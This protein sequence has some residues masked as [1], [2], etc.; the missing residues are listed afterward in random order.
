MAVLV[1]QTPA[2]SQV[3]AGVNA[4]PTQVDATH[5]V[6][7]AYRRQAAEPSQK[8]SVPHELAPWSVHWLSGSWPA[9]TAVHVPTLPVSAHDWQVPVQAVAQ[10]KPCAQKPELHSAAAPQAAPIGFL[11]Q[12][13][14]MQV[15]GDVQSALVVHEVLHAEV[16]HT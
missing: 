11:P 1:R 13:P 7:V 5:V 9:G 8:P 15:L 16:P 12:L 10:Q 6:P 3:R 2:P 14:A 4:V